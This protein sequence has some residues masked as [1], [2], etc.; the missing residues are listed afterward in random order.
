MQTFLLVLL[1]II[2]LAYILKTQ[3]YTGHQYEPYAFMI[4]NDH[5]DTQE[6]Q[7]PGLKIE[8]GHS[9]G[10]VCI[11]D[12]NHPMYGRKNWE[13]D[14]EGDTLPTPINVLQAHGG[15]TLTAQDFERKGWVIGFDTVHYKDNS[16][17][18]DYFYVLE[19][20]NYLLQQVKDYK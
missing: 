4:S 20:I 14:D 11:Q 1:S 7:I 19:E 9:N 6:R 17:D 10:Y 3:D 5:W 12:P 8:H 15:I 18:Q 13:T 2:S 16:R